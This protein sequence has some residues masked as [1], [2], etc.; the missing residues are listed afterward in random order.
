MRMK[1]VT[2][3]IAALLAVSML[4]ACS[5]GNESAA[6]GKETPAPPTVD[7]TQPVTLTVA[8]GFGMSVEDFDKSHGNDI[9]KKFPNVTLNYIA[10]GQ[11]TS[12]PE[13]V[14]AGTYPD[15]VFGGFSDVDNYLINLNL[16]MDITPLAKKHGYDLGRFEPG[17]LDAIK[18]TTSEGS[19]IG[20]PMPYGGMHVMFYNKAIFD[21]FGVPYPKDSMTW[22]DAYELAKKMTRNEGGEIYRGFSSF[23]GAV[24]RDNQLSV[25][26]L[27]TKTDKMFNPEKWK[28]LLLNL[29]RFYEIPNNMRAEGTSQIAEA[30]A[31]D[32]SQKVALAVTQFGAYSGF[33]EELNWDMVTMP[34]FKEL[35]NTSGMIAGSTSYWYITKTNKNPDIT[36]K[37]VEYLLS[38][39]RQIAEA[40]SKANM[41]SVRTIK[42]LDKILGSDMPK[43]KGKNMGAVTKMKPAAAPPARAQGLVGANMNELKKIIES[44]MNKLIINKLDINTVLREAEEAMDKQV[45]AKKNQ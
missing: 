11:G 15:L 41:P 5:K 45:E 22:D 4:S 8:S 18:T 12:I 35:P 32:K 26:Y 25:P 30:G 42:D 24:L 13:L 19:L 17:M 1:A 31:F 16:H 34:T 10:R 6:S 21:K 38:D 27:D 2:P 14:A 39:E 33:P 29:S 40:K 3:A 44:S 37:I 36:F 7:L 23:Y 20:L 28:E 43:L 9:R